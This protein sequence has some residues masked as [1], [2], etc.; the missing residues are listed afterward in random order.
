MQPVVE[1]LSGLERR[2][3]LSVPVAEVEKEV[4]AQLKAAQRNAKAPGFRPGKVPMSMLERTHAPGI[5]MDVINSKVGDAFEKAVSGAELRVAGM[6]RIEPKTE[7]APEDAIAFVATF[8]VYPEVTLPEL[9]ALEVER[10]KTAVGDAEIERTLDILRQQRTRFEP[11]EGRA[12]ED[13]DQVTLDFEGKI[14]DVAFEGGTAEDFSFVLGQGRMLPEFEE[15]ARGLK[16]GETKTFP[17]VFPEDYGSPTVAGKTAQ[18]TITVK[19]VAQGVLPEVDTEFAKSLGQAEGDVQ[20]LRDDIRA[21][22]ER[23]VENRTLAR[24]KASVMNA[25][26][27]AAQFDVPKALVEND[28]QGRVQAAREE[29]RQRGVPN[30][31]SMPIPAEAFATESERRVRLGLLV[32]E[33]VR[34]DNLQAKPDQVRAKIETFAKNY[35][36]PTEVVRYYLSDRSRLAEVEAVVLEDNVVEHVLSKAK[37]TEQEVPFDELMGNNAA[38]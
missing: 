7:D 2:V 8:E 31:D 14:D 10:A 26:A 6:P 20:K 32:S 34:R 23:E 29:L 9:D 13:N 12:A 36:Q 18:F 4:Q 25:L 33:L 28:T 17:L 21:N 24:T 38:N 22:L 1:T 5:R 16:A 30:A 19:Q 3:E 35:E 27:G 11:A 37:V 15:A